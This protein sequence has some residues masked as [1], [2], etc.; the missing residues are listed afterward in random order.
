MEKITLAAARV[1]AG[2]SLQEVADKINKD[3][4]TISNWERGKVEMRVKDFLTLCKLYNVPMDSI[5]LPTT[6][7]K[8]E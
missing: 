3:R 7:H 1:N 4:S 8:V 6:L 2:L 5:I